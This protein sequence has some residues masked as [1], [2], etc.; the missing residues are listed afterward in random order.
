MIGGWIVPMTLRTASAFLA[1][2]VRRGMS[3]VKSSSM[4]KG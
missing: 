1:A 4:E 2:P 3:T